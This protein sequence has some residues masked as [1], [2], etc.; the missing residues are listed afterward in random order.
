MIYIHRLILIFYPQADIKPQTDGNNGKVQYNLTPEIMAA[1]FKTYP[2]VKKKHSDY[3]PH[4]MSESEFWTRFF[5]SHYYSVHTTSRSENVFSECAKSD[6][7]G[8]YLYHFHT[9]F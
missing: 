9:I 3:V 1:V 4:R 7:K 8:I 5:Q 2:T 6:D